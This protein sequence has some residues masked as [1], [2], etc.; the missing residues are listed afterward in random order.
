MSIDLL[1]YIERTRFNYDRESLQITDD[2]GMFVAELG[3]PSLILPNDSLIHAQG[4]LMAAAP[5]LRRRLASLLFRYRKDCPELRYK[6]FLLDHTWKF[7]DS[8]LDAS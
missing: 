8:I 3:R 7:I 4:R 6:A 2:E 1:S 5:E